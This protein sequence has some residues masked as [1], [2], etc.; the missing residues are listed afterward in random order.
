MRRVDR[1][2]APATV[3]AAVP[4]EEWY[5]GLL[6][7]A[8]ASPR[9]RLYSRDRPSEAPRLGDARAAEVDRGAAEARCRAAQS[10]P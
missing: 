10:E 9:T 1:L 6:R 3:A 4:L 7:A 8:A 5:E 2:K